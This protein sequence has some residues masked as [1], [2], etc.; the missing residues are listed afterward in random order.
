MRRSRLRRKP[1]GERGRNKIGWK[2]SK[3]QKKN[4]EGA[5]DTGTRRTSSSGSIQGA[6]GRKSVVRWTQHMYK[7]MYN[8]ED[9]MMKMNHANFGNKLTSRFAVVYFRHIRLDSFQ[10]TPKLCSGVDNLVQS[11]Q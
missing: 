1:E 6:R 7:N 2:E 4:G 11:T 10:S 9:D 8:M 5:G 3:R